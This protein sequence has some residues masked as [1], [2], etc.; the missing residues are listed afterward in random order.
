MPKTPGF[1][2]LLCDISNLM[3]HE[4]GKLKKSSMK[5]RHY[6]RFS[7]LHVHFDSSTPRSMKRS[8]L[9]SPASTLTFILHVSAGEGVHPFTIMPDP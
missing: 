9:P 1:A 7:A 6:L 8:A 2:K 5:I 3:G 4:Y